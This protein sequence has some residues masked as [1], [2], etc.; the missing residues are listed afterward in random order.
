MPTIIIDDR[1]NHLKIE[2]IWAFVSVDDDGNEGVCAAQLMGPGSLMPLI[3][4]DPARLDSLRP[5]A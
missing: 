1:D 2:S 5:I 4:A 3:A